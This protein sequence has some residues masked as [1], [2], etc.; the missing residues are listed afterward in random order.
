VSLATAPAGGSTVTDSASSAVATGSSR[1]WQRQ[2]RRPVLATLS[3]AVAVLVLLPLVFLVLQAG[4]A[5]WGEVRTLLFRS[6]TWQLLRNTV[7]LAVLVT[8]ACIAI[9]VSTAWVVER[10]NVPLRRV[11]AVLLVLPFAIPDFVTG[12]AWSSIFPAVHGLWGAVLVMTLGLYPLVFLPVAAA[13]RGADPAQE[14]VAR[15]LGHGRIR[16]FARVTLPSLRPALLGGGLVVCL[17]LFAEFGAFEILR[18]QTF[19]TTIFTEFQIGFNGPAASAL[20]LALVALGLIALGAE[21]LLGSGRGGRH[22]EGGRVLAASRQASR[23]PIRRRLGGWTAPV[24]IALAALAALALG[25][26]AA[27]L[28]YWMTQ[29]HQTTLPGVSMVAA[30][31]HTAA[32]SAA[33]A[34]LATILAL[35]VALYTVRR[36][37]RVAAI[38]QRSTLVVQALPGLVIALAAVFYA[39]HYAPWVYQTPELLVVAY[40][41]L[42]YPLAFVAVRASVVL[43]PP[44]LDEVARSLGRRPA[45]VLVRVTIPLIA[46]GLA[47][48]F[49]L[50]FLT[51]VTELTAT[52]I[53]VPTGVQTLA[54][55]FWAYQHDASY[56][57]AAPYAVALVAIAAIPSYL[58]GRWFDRL[59]SRRSIGTRA[60]D[61]E[62]SGTGAD[63]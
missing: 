21:G 11:W 43:A 48:A 3:V 13:L 2:R 10:T 45:A 62:P 60:A 17:T 12:Y 38:L 26:P 7:E 50:V 59:P 44:R 35:P 49:C 33:A 29:S 56:G 14:E 57:A 36:G 46:P 25:M 31:A 24:L 30:A 16:T 58:I 52:L 9:G 39:I 41:I 53:L 19:T 34:A 47:A 61:A 18:F 5:G 4:Q 28:T 6:L 55:Q 22:S 37:G 40:A 8:A 15:S 20:S 1:R 27:A 32:Y 54:T 42:F 51:A 23:M 63:R